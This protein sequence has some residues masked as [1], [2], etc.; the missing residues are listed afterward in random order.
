MGSLVDEKKNY[1]ANQEPKPICLFRPKPHPKG[2]LLWMDE[3]HFAPRRLKP[4]FV[5]IC[6][7]SHPPRVSDRWCRISRPSTV[8]NQLEDLP[9]G[10]CERPVRPRSTPRP[11]WAPASAQKGQKGGQCAGGRLIPAIWLF[12]PRKKI[13]LLSTPFKTN[14]GKNKTCS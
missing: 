8:W 2:H 11:V 6:G 14:K 1:P 13:T 10:A 9:A 3:I 4:W 5:G 12:G 7:E